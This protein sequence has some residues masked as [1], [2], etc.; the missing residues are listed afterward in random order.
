MNSII[1]INSW[2]RRGIGGRKATFFFA[3]YNIKFKSIVEANLLTLVLPLSHCC[4]KNNNNVSQRQL[5]QGL[6][7]ESIYSG[8]IILGRLH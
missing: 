2:Y 6:S 4:N 3:N 1:A 5:K 7:L 8:I